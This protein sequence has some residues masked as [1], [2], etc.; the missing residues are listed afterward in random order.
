MQ[1]GRHSLKYRRVQQDLMALVFQ[2]RQLDV[3]PESGRGRAIRF[4]E[5]RRCHVILA[6]DNHADCGAVR[7]SADQVDG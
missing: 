3:L 4:A 7:D 5:G 2:F 6:T 1:K